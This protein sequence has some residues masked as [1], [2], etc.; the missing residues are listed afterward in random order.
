[1]QL[2]ATPDTGLE[3]IQRAAFFVLFDTVNNALPLV[4]AAWAASDQSFSQRT[5]R[6]HVPTTLERVENANFHEGLNPS[7]IQSP[8]DKFPNVS[9]LAYRAT[10][11]PGSD[12]YDHQEVYRVTLVIE[13]MVRSSEKEGTDM[14]NRRAHRMV[15]AIHTCMMANKNLGGIVSGFDGTPTTNVTEMFTRKDRGGSSSS[16]GA[17]TSYGPEWFWQGGRLEYAVRKEA[18]MPSHGSNFRNAP[19]YDGLSVDQI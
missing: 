13:T 16:R 15:Q 12:L 6:V 17:R 10:P 7:L 1:M 4:E 8:A 11:G 14:C 18:T 2:V 19:T 9:V 5:G 3:Q